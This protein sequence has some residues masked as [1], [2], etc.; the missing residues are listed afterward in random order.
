MMETGPLHK[1]VTE[2][3]EDMPAQLQVAARFLLDHPS[4]VALLSMR[5][6]A[7]RAGVPPATMTRLAQRL[8]FKGFDSVRQLYAESMRGRSDAFRDRTEGLVAR[9]DLDGDAALVSDMLVGL[10]HHLRGLSQ[11]ETLAVMGRAADLLA[12]CDRVFC[13]GMRSSFPAMH[14]ASYL[15]SLIGLQ[16]TLV[17]GPGGIGLDG[18]RNL[19]PS[20]AVLALSIRPYTNSTV[21]AT[22]YAAERGASVIAIT[23]SV[24]S[25]L[26]RHACETIIVPTEAPS[27]LH[28]MAPA[29]VVVECMA[30]LVA[31]R[32]GK[33]AVKAIEEAETHLDRFNAYVQERPKG[34]RKS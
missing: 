12:R 21:E 17:D 3:F 22:A 23:D 19:S 5:E 20:D 7:K 32:R 29:F 10:T 13:I 33:S 18:L 1:V 30:S 34:R 9:R 26:V 25:P 24:V 14:L 27:F 11:P 4:E 6:Q 2:Q 31:A 8:G 15:L 16:T 28:T